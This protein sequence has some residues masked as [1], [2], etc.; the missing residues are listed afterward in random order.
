MAIHKPSLTVTEARRLAKINSA[1]GEV[2]GGLPPAIFPKKVE[3]TPEPKPV[4][5]KQETT[6]VSPQLKSPFSLVTT[7]EQPAGPERLKEPA[8]V[9][10]GMALS[11]VR[12]T[13][14]KPSPRR[15]SG[16]SPFAIAGAYAYS[17][18][19]EDKVQVYVSALQ[20]AP[21]VSA[22]FDTLLTNYSS[23]KALQ[24]ILRRALH[25]YDL[26]LE[27]GEFLKYAPGYDINPATAESPIQ[28]SRMMPKKVLALAREH[29]DPLGLESTRAFGRKLATAALA[30]FFAR[31]RP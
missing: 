26:S 12:R 16:P 2:D 20:P 4:T 25:D 22:M 21:G 29:F 6:S 15:S 24:M 1:L 17:P 31:H 8:P 23:R 9:Q 5:V 3:V 10:T 27:N 30:A 13:A 18:L 11:A 7:A 28:T 19:A 14:D